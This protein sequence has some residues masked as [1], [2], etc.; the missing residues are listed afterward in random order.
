MIWIY[1]YY[2]DLIGITRRAAKI[3]SGYKRLFVDKFITQP[4]LFEVDFNFNQRIESAVLK[5]GN[6]GPRESPRPKVRFNVYSVLGDPNIG[7]CGGTAISKD[8]GVFDLVGAREF[9]GSGVGTGSDKE[10]PNS[11][12]NEYK[13]IGVQAQAQIQ[14]QEQGC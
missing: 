12:R 14:E 1:E 13:K 3:F 6:S 8:K 7:D 9:F 4:E 11:S 10:K 2:K 5:E